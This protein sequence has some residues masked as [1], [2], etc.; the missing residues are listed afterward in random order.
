MR[1]VHKK[2]VRLKLNGTHQ[3]LVY[4][5]NINIL[6]VNINT[7]NKNIEALNN[8][9]KDDGL[10]VTEKTKYMLTSHHQNAGYN[11]N[12]EMANRYVENMVRSNILEQ[13]YQIKI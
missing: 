6:G 10:E 12:T 1:K 9:S 4:A 13:Q 5:N 7:I 8:I 3:L 11:H 2:E